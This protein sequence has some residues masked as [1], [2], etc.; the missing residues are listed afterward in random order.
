MANLDPCRV[1]I[2]NLNGD[3][4]F[5]DTRASR[6]ECE[7]VA[8]QKW[9]LSCYHLTITPITCAEFVNSQL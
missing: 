6:K 2:T 7:N 9:N 8:W 4:I 1:E 3:V 5:T